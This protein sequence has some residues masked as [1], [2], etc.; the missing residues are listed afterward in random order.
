MK[1]EQSKT[2]IVAY[3]DLLGFSNHL[4][5]N[6][7][8]ALMVINNYNNILSFKKREEM[9]NPVSSYPKELQEL[10]KRSSIDSFDYF[11]PFSDS[12]FLMSSDCNSFVKQLCNFVLESFRFTADFYN[13]PINTSKPE[14]SY[15]MRCDIKGDGTITVLHNECKYYPVLFR[16]G[17][18]YGEA[19]SAELYSVVNKEASKTN[20]IT[21]KAI[22]KAVELEKKV[23]GPRLIFGVEVFDQLDKSTQDYCRLIPEMSEIYELL[24]PAM[25]YIYQ[26]DNLQ[27]HQEIYKFCD[28]I[29]PVYTLWRAYKHTTQ[30]LHYFNFIELI[31]AS[32]IQIFDK[33]FGLKQFAK[34]YILNWLANNELENKID[35]NKY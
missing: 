23:K 32:T 5:E 24:W 21:G 11:L 33:K 4:S 17:L 26:N 8:D 1:S 12:I 30:T 18:A 25:V 34:D 3:I 14:S 9:R 7:N 31:I 29:S 6:T 16:G 19:F 20:I 10:A 27:I 13:N 22:V 28:L 15:V 35:L 2:N